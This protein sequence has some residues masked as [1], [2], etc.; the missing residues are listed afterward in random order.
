MS[1]DGKTQIFITKLS[2]DVQ[3]DELKSEFTQ[4]GEIASIQLKNGYAFIDF[5]EASSAREAIEK[6][7]GKRLGD[8]NVVVEYAKEKKYNI[9]SF[10][11]G[12]D[13]F[14]R[15]RDRD[16]RD[17]FGPRGMNLYRGQGGV[18]CYNCGRKGHFA[19]DCKE[20]PQRRRGYSDRR[21]YAPRRRYDDDKYEHSRNRPR[22]QRSR[23][24]SRNRSHSRSSSKRYKKEEYEYSHSR[25]RRKRSDSRNRSHHRNHSRSGRRYEEGRERRHFSGEKYSEREKE[26]YRNSRNER[27]EENE[28]NFESQKEEIKESKEENFEKIPEE[29]QKGFED[30]SEDNW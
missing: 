23:S 6:T 7:N 21:E 2:P 5:T 25:S 19:R 8:M 27:K 22:F 15:Y 20:S 14:N 4:Y 26:F 12:E 3:I 9:S 13:S 24:D 16:S 18:I 10:H 17:K 11:R 30:K 28:R 29:G 1:D